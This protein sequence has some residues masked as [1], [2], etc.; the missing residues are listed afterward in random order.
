MKNLILKLANPD[1]FYKSNPVTNFLNE[2]YNGREELKVTK[3]YL[4]SFSKDR[5]L[6]EKKIKNSIIF[7]EALTVIL[8]IIIISLI[9]TYI[10]LK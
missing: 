5:L 3:K 4:Q 1:L 8:Y 10:K 6:L 2:I 9:I 7:F